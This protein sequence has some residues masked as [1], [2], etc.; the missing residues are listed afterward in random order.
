MILKN[1]YYIAAERSEETFREL[2][3]EERQEK[4]VIKR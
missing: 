1:E 2:I 3:E 4:V